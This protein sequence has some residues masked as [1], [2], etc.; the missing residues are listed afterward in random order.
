MRAAFPGVRKFEKKIIDEDEN[1][2]ERVMDVSSDED[3]REEVEVL[4]RTK[5]ASDTL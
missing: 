2:A 4:E 3:V 1:P 5:S